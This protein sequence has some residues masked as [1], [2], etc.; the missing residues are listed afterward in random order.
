MFDKVSKRAS[1]RQD[2]FKEGALTLICEVMIGDVRI[3]NKIT[4][5]CKCVLEREN[6]EI[7]NMAR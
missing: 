3:V 4:E 5:M 6:C 2:S 1:S 7:L